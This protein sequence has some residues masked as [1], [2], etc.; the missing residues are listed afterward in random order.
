MDI[1]ELPERPRLV[2]LALTIALVGLGGCADLV[3]ADSGRTIHLSDC[4]PGAAPGC[5][6]GSNSNPGTATAPLRDLS[7]LDLN[8]LPAGSS[9]LFARGGAWNVA[10]RLA[11]PFVTSAAPLT[12]ADYGSGALPLLRTPAGI[13]FM[14]GRYG[15][16]TVDGGY[17]LRNLRLDGMGTGQWGAF[18]QG[19]T[20]DVVFD[21]IEASGFD[22]GIHS[23]Q[24]AQ[25]AN[26]RL[27][28]R[29]AYLH[30]N[31]EHGFLGNSNGLL[32]EG[33]RFEDNN[34]SG[35]GREHGAY[36]GGNS[37]GLT[38]RNSFFR[39][40]SV[41]TASGRCDGGNLTVHGQHERVVIEGNL[42]EQSASDDG[43]FGISVTAGY[44]SPEWMR[45]AVIRGNTIV[46]LG[47][48][49]ICVSAAPGALIEA[50]KIYNSQTRWHVGILIP[51]IR[52]GPGDE[53][54]RDAMIRDN[55]ICHAGPTTGSAGVNAPS[56]AS[57][58]GT[59]YRT[60]AAASTGPCAR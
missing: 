4:Q 39:R 1:P 43:C 17:V 41:N 30:H 8:A 3:Q 23:Q 22:I 55:L 52:I 40:N 36:L 10:T 60:G 7:G 35:G 19:A 28:V 38:V 32:I 49:A 21:G 31:R 46:N 29:N 25:S 20:R 47:A 2:R 16:T 18:V 9:V 56:A 45:N 6:P 12:L 27:V 37:S 26:D 34:P 5:V 54:D 24:T 14:F 53:A 59:V 33:T 51:A 11:N 15:D 48:C 42:I 58:T 44:N 57:V 13:T 50:N